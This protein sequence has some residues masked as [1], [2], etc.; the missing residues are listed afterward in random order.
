MKDENYER[1]RKRVKEIK[2]FYSNLITYLVVNA[3]LVIIN[4][5][6]SPNKLWFYWVTIFWGIGIIFSAYN[7]FLRKGRFLG[8]DWEEKKVKEIMDR[9]EKTDS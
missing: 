2:G 6:T 4:L 9:Q 1:V 3:V 5:V 7:V 8:E